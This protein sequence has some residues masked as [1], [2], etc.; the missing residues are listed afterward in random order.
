M[1]YRIITNGHYFKVQAKAL[2]GWIDYVEG[3]DCF[4]YGEEPTRHDTEA[5]AERKA[6]GM[7][8]SSAVRE[9][10]PWTAV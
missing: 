7:W 3:D 8:G 6:R 4:G 2:F 5:N 1:R 9:P 10:S